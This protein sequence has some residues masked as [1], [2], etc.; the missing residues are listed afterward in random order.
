MPAYQFVMPPYQLPIYKLNQDEGPWERLSALIRV[1]YI[2]RS[3]PR[4]RIAQ[5][6]RYISV[7]SQ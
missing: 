1:E 5:G 3:L 2:Y 7:I 4:K 6:T